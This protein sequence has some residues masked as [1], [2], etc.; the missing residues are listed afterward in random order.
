MK[1]LKNKD[2]DLIEGKNEIRAPKPWPAIGKPPTP[3]K[4][5][6]W[7]KFMF[8]LIIEDG[9]ADLIKG[10][11]IIIGTDAWDKIEREYKDE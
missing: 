2:Q 3:K 11:K 6:N 4:V 10:I 7:Y 9:D 8:N 5:S 1:P